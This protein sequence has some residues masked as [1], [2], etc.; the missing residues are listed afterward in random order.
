LRE[1]AA[2]QRVVIGNQNAAAAPAFLPSGQ[3][4]NVLSSTPIVR[5]DRFSVETLPNR[6]ATLKSDP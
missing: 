6:L 4:P 2:H 3:C 5:P 1:R